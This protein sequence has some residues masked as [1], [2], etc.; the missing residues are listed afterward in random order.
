MV[1]TT[2]RGECVGVRWSALECVGN[3][4]SALEVRKMDVV[5][6]ILHCIAILICIYHLRQADKEITKIVRGKKDDCH[7]HI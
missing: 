1:M 2:G 6:N 4:L 7:K 3:A 5:L